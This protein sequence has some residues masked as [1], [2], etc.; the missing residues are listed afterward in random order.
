[1]RHPARLRETMRFVAFR[2]FVEADHLDVANS[3]ASRLDGFVDTGW[4]REDATVRA[5][6]RA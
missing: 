4:Q 6:R 2:D 5:F 1:M 3:L